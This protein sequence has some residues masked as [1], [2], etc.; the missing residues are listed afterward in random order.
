MA[1]A[2]GYALERQ[3]AEEVLI[4]SELRYRRLF[5]AA[6]DGILILDAQT[7]KVADVNPFLIELLGFSHG[8]FIGKQLWELGFYKDI[9][10][11]KAQFAELQEK[12]YVRYKDKP[13]KT[14]DGRLIDVEFVSN[15]Y[16]VNHHEVIQCNVRDISDR[17][18]AEAE[19]RSRDAKYQSLV[20]RA[21]DGIFTINVEGRF[22]LANSKLC[23]MLGYTQEECLRRNILDTYP[24]EIRPA[25]LQ[26]LTQLRCGEALRF[27]RPMK[28]KDGGTVLV[29]ASAEWRVIST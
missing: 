22:L 14:A 18:R 3:R 29:E 27:E 9:A 25:G 26:R 2:A 10:E 1:Q 12:K 23:Q 21:E 19:I 17:K 6:K 20:E 5:E 11:N 4:A 28:R 15:V 13:L 24:D 16:Q 8:A 7:G